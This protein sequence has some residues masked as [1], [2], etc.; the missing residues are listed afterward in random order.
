MNRHER[1]KAKVLRSEIVK[2]GPKE[3]RAILESGMECAWNECPAYYKGPM[4]QG[5]R[6][7]LVFWSHN[8]IARIT[9]IPGGTWDR[10]AVLCP[11]HAQELD[12]LLKN[13]GVPLKGAVAGSA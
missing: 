6:N 11:Q 3:A 9:D 1:R 10:D 5:W 4:P 13:I 12:A 7:L 2:I 8:P